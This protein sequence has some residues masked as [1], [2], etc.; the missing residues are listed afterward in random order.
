MLLTPKRGGKL[1]I[2]VK[3][4]RNKKRYRKIIFNYYK[5]YYRLIF[6]NID[7]FKKDLLSRSFSSMGIKTLLPL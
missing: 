7:V 1:L 4:E 3:E 5:R 2:I 6:K